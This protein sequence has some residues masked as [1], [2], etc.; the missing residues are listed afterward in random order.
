MSHAIRQVETHKVTLRTVMRRA[1]FVQGHRSF[2]Q[3][4]P[5]L[6]DA[7][8]HCIN[9]QWSYERGRQFAALFP[10]PVKNKNTIRMDALRAYATALNR[11]E[12][13]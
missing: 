10:H 1:S 4:Q 6:Y 8:P 13:L 12:I 3:G 11:R 2:L 5:L 9:E 7:Y